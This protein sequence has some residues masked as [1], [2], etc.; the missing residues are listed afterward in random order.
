MVKNEE[1]NLKRCLQSVCKSVDEIVVVDTGSTDKTVSIAK[2]F[3][4][5][6]YHHPWQNDFS[7]HRNQSVGYAT[8]DWLFQ[9]DADE[10]MIFDN[11]DPGA[12]AAWLKIVPAGINAAGIRLKD[13]RKGEIASQFDAVRLFRAGKVKYEGIVHNN[14]VYEGETA[15]FTEGHLRHYGYDLD[16]EKKEAKALRTI[17]LLEKRL[18]D[19]PEDYDAMFYMAEALGSYRTIEES[20]VWAE[21]YANSRDK[22]K[23]FNNS[24]YYLIV[25]S[26]MRMGNYEKMYEWLGRGFEHIP[27]DLDLTMAFLH[28]G[29][30]KKRGDIIASGARAFC[31]NYDFFDQTAAKRGGTFCFNY[32]PTSYAYALY[33]LALCGMEEAA[34]AISLLRKTFPQLPIGLPDDFEKNLDMN[35][36]A[37]GLR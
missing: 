1:E 14:P 4:A 31:K 22:I 25:N 19:N 37:V 5:K 36:K 21:K 20:L 11:Y 24:I 28:Y 17:S 27:D 32:K 33:Q 10:Q 26:Y 29:I 9:I 13:I 2:G 7:F 34:G 16:P 8:G 6:I 12:L 35:L 30:H 23:T 3:G 18:A 15:F